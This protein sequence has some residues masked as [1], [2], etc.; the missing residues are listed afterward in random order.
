MTSSFDVSVPADGDYA[1]A[2]DIWAD[3]HAYEVMIWTNQQGAVSPIASAYDGNGPIPEESGVVLGGHT[4]NI[5][6]GSNGS[7]AVFSFVRT[8]DTNSG[9][10]DVLAVLTWLRTQGWWAD[11][12]I[13]DVEFGFELTGTAGRSDFVCNDFVLDY[14]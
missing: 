4:W 9:D 3:N 14:R 2:Y 12:T 11:V 13:D 1:T 5:Y 8:G 7:N 10:V 6:R